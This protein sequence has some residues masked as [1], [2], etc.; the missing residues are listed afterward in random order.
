MNNSLSIALNFQK[1][2]P[3]Y[4]HSYLNLYDII[5]DSFDERYLLYNHILSALSLAF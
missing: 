4:L 3:F 1:I 2:Q 5:G